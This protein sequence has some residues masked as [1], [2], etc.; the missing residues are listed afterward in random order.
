MADLSV[1]ASRRCH[2]LNRRS[3]WP[4]VP[5]AVWITLSSPVLS[6]QPFAVRRRLRTTTAVRRI[7]RRLR[8]LLRFGLSH[9]NSSKLMRPVWHTSPLVI[10]MTPDI[11]Y[12]RRRR[13]PQNVGSDSRLSSQCPLAYVR[14]YF[15]PF[16]DLNTPTSDWLALPWTYA[17]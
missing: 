15:T 4:S 17:V 5:G 6:A 9:G 7:R 13:E 16:E 1:A 14:R 10:T 12:E 2:P 8:I 11:P 3:P